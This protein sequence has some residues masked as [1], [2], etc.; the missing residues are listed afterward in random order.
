MKYTKDKSGLP[1]INLLKPN[2]L[3]KLNNIFNTHWHPNRLKSAQS[4]S[5]DELD[6]LM[7][8][9]PERGGYGL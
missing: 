8:A 1:L 3:A 5:F 9:K 6:R 7:R 4:Y 2:D